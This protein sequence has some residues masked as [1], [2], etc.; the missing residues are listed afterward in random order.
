MK[1]YLHGSVFI[2]ISTVSSGSDSTQ[3]IRAPT[4]TFCALNSDSAWALGWKNLSGGYEDMINNECDQPDNLEDALSCV[5][6]RT[7]SFHETI[8]LAKKGTYNYTNISDIRFWGS[9][10]T[11]ISYGKCH[12]LNFTE[13][14]GSK[15]EKD[16]LWFELDSNLIYD[17]TIHD[18]NYYIATVRPA[19]VPGVQI[20]K[21]RTLESKQFDVVFVSA[22]KHINI[23]QPEKPC[24][25]SPS[26]SFRRCVK[27]SVSR[28]IGCRMVWDLDSDPS[29][30][31]CNQIEQLR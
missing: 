27:E 10:L 13:D 5:N 17:I 1:K 4:V 3:Q 19:I 31:L 24:N 29:W 2:E 28:K 9:D 6:N 22:T 25:V 12:T 15:P 23:N 26:H 11:K 21:Q 8:K 7:Y 18:P 30:P 20:R 14:I 16:I